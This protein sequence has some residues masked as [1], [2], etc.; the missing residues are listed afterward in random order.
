MKKPLQAEVLR[1]EAAFWDALKQ[2]VR[3]NPAQTCH[4]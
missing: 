3:D 1:Q 2:A 4:K